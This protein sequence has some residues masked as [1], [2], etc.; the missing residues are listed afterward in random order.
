[1]AALE[2]RVTA[3]ERGGRLV[4]PA[5]AET[6]RAHPH[7]A[8]VALSARVTPV[9]AEAPPPGGID[10]PAWVAAA[11]SPVAAAPLV[12]NGAPAEVVEAIG[13]RDLSTLD[14]WIAEWPV[15]I[16]AVA[17]A[18]KGLAGVL[19]DCKPVEADASSVTIG[20]TGRFHHE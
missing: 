19:R 20:T 9:A 12:E 2:L 14:G 3:L 7:A 17:R 18:N 16:E 8:A 6:L 11:P 4:A 15:A 1:M 10:P 13:R 5:A